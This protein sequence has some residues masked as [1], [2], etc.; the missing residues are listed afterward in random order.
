[1]GSEPEARYYR[2]ESEVYGIRSGRGERARR[3][4]V[5]RWQRLHLE[6]VHRFQ[7]AW[8]ASRHPLLG[9]AAAP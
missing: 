7:T 6:D 4:R 3:S 1:M 8:C 5:F 9:R 2:R